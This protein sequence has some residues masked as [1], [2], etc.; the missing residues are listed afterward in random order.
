M[1]LCIFVLQT[2][3]FDQ[4][5]PIGSPLRFTGAVVMPPAENAFM[6]VEIER[7]VL[8]PGKSF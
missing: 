2:Q 5:T 8:P 6:H 3:P 4:A 1:I 7:A